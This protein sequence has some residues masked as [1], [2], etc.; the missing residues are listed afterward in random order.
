MCVRNNFRSKTMFLV[1]QIALLLF[2]LLQLL[3]MRLHP[4]FHPDLMDGVRGA[5]LGIAIGAVIAMGRGK[6]G[7]AA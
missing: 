6:R 3:P 2:G 4:E 1:S 5:F 7:R